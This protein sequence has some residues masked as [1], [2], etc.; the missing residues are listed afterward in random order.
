V[1]SVVL[2][3]PYGLSISSENVYH[4]HSHT[5]HMTNL[6]K[7]KVV[8]YEWDAVDF[9]FPKHTALGVADKSSGGEHLFNWHRWWW[10][11]QINKCKLSQSRESSHFVS[12]EFN[13]V[14]TNFIHRKS[15]LQHKSQRLSE[16]QSDRVVKDIKN[17][18]SEQK[19]NKTCVY[20][21]RQKNKICHK[22]K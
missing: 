21:Y 11:R 20:L 12:P 17:K 8:M 4:S 5:S 14:I 15:G 18:T 2:Y 19:W 7:V 16:W 13:Y 3:S 1:T 9:V 6:K 10:H 22:A